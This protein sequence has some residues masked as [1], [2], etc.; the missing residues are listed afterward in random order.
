M[1]SKKITIIF[2][3]T[4]L[5]VITLIGL[6]TPVIGQAF[7]AN[8][9]QKYFNISVVISNAAPTITGVSA[10]SG[11]PT[12]G[13]TT[14]VHIYFNVTDTNGY[15]DVNP[16]Q[17]SANVTFNGVTRS[18]ASCADYGAW[19]GGNIRGVDCTINMNY[20]DESSASWDISVR[21]IDG[22]VAVANDSNANTMTYDTLYAFTLEQSNIN[23]NSASPG[24]TG[25]N[26]SDDPQV[27]NNTG[28]GAFTK[29][30][31][32]GHSLTNGE[33]TIGAGNFT[34]NAT[35]DAAGMAV[36]SNILITGASLSVN[37]TQNLYV[38]LDL[39]SGLSNGTYSTN[40]TTNWLI[41][42]YN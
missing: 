26:A 19:T 1:S 9:T 42:A 22:A 31:I 18:S 36:G 7:G 20:Y 30:N 37:S 33:D 6:F 8:N 3:T 34:V 24:A 32:T 2:L 12:E 4:I 16:T 11:T 23:F 38:W 21:A 10:A 35:A 41:E 28:N 14:A 27:L 25:L 40:S 15:T 13:T 17:A 39:P 29:I 5:C